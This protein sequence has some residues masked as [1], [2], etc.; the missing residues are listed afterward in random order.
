MTASRARRRPVGQRRDVEGRPGP[1]GPPV[2]QGRHRWVGRWRDR[3]GGRAWTWDDPGAH[4]RQPAKATGTWMLSSALRSVRHSRD[5]DRGRGPPGPP[6]RPARSWS[7]WSSGPSVGE[8]IGWLVVDELVIEL[9][10][11]PARFVVEAAVAGAGGVAGEGA[12][13]HRRR[14]EVVEAAAMEAGGVA[15]EGA[16]AH[17]QRTGEHSSTDYGGGVEDAAAVAWRSC[18]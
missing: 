8:N 7:R 18:R 13:A 5:L 1:G 16:A 6:R 4:R 12:A 14:P 3:R 17:R 15:G 9:R 11:Q 10:Q 2:V